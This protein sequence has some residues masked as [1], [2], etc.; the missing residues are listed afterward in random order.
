MDGC[1]DDTALLSNTT[2]GL[3]QLIKAAK[4]HS[5]AKDLLLNVKKTKIRHSD[6]CVQETVI[7]I[8][9]ENIENVKHFEYLGSRMEGDG[10]SRNEI[11]RRQAIANQKLA[12]MLKL[13]KGQHDSFENLK[14]MHISSSRVRV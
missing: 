11:R 9:G 2:E 6:K 4:E 1:A 3:K 12:N 7:V 8:D 14:I 10:R 13:W 5:E